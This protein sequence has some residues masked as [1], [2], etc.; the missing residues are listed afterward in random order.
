MSKRRPYRVNPCDEQAERRLL[1]PARGLL[2]QGGNLGVRIPS[3]RCQA[4]P[5]GGRGGQSSRR[6]PRLSFYSAPTTWRA[7]HT[8]S[9]G[10]R[11][12]S[13]P[14]AAVSMALTRVL[15][16]A[17]APTP[18]AWRPADLC[19]RSVP[20]MLADKQGVGSIAEE[21]EARG[22]DPGSCRRETSRCVP[23]ATSASAAAALRLSWMSA[24]FALAASLLVRVSA[25]ALPS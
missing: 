16:H 8:V 3:A 1:A 7:G 9:G 12:P 18:T 14:P 5:S 17:V 20:G 25:L 11:T 19:R 22:L 21:L 24:A 10:E 13:H 2:L 6:G 23:S 15:A 4:R